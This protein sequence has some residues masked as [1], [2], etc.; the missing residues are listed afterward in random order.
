MDVLTLSRLQFAITAMFHFIF[1]P[2]TLGLSVMVAYMESCYV[3]TNNEMYLK[4]TKFWGKLFLINFAL[5]LVTGITMEFQF[6]MN[7]AQYSKYVGDI[8]G[9]PLAIEATL[10]FF[11]ES[12]F[13]GLWIFGWNKVSKRV[14]ATSIWIVAIATNISGLLIILA[15][16]WMQNP[17]GYVLRNNR[18]E[19]VDFGAL[20]T[21]PIGWLQFGH[22]LS[23]AYVLAAFFVMG[24]SA[25]HL[26]KSNKTDFFKKSFRIAATVALIFSIL[27]FIVGDFSAVH[28]ANTQPAKFAAMESVWETQSSAPY[29]LLVV[30]DEQ[31]E[32]NSLEAIAIPNMLSYLAFHDATAQVTGLKA[33]P[34][35]DRPPVLI[36]FLSFR[37]M[38]GLGMLIILLSIIAFVVSKRDSLEANPTFLRIMLYSIPLPYIAIQLGWIVTEVGRQPWIVYGVLRT[39]DAVSKA[40]SP[41]QVWGSLIGFTL[42]YGSLGIIDIY[43][44]AKYAKKGPD[45]DLSAI[46]KT[47]RMEA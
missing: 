45:D 14:H 6:G 7:W 43:L 30:P 10:A 26:L 24:I 33:V 42:L 38:V 8:F 28:V 32:R 25:Y 44:L 18:A 37:V 35:Q 23:S 16:G 2:L 29:N 13:L 34:T 40:I 27:V 9:A 21:N 15:N 3:R 1:V 19:M 4:M 39:S 17:V 41:T 46:I 22:T 12:T 36:T 31:N 11:L 47:S 5:G 20:V